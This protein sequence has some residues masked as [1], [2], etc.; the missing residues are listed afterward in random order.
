[1]VK[2]KLK[3][4]SIWLGMRA[5]YI[6]II[7]LFSSFAINGSRSIPET[8][9]FQIAAGLIAIM[10]LVTILMPKYIKVV[11]FTDLI[12]IIWLMLFGWEIYEN[13]YPDRAGWFAVLQP[14]ALGIFIAFGSSIRA[15]LYR[16]KFIY[17]RTPNYRENLS[18]HYSNVSRQRG[19]P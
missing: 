8:N 13:L 5:P 3:Q 18:P 14:L 1:M 15:K 11:L 16:P 19:K 17:R 4:Y 6:A 2:V 9:G 12:T 7:I 10:Q